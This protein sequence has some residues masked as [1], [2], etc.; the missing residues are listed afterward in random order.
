MGWL[1]LLI[2]V[3]TVYF[4]LAYGL[5]KRTRWTWYA[6]WVVLFFAAGA[7]AFY[8]MA[9]LFSAETISQFILAAVFTA[10]G[11]ALWTLFAVHWC[12]YK[13]KF[14]LRNKKNT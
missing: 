4:G 7:V 13:E 8:T 14:F 5:Q 9:M 3:P 2:L 1:P 6:G 11:T 12:G 10:G